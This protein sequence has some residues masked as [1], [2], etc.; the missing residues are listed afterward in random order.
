M[1]RE[2]GLIFVSFL[3]SS[4]G[5]GRRAVAYIAG[6]SLGEVSRELVY[7]GVTAAASRHAGSQHWVN[8]ARPLD[9]VGV[10]RGRMALSVSCG[11]P[12]NGQGLE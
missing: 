4:E 8:W 3:T 2:D 11:C 9:T 5:G 7:C 12:C 1:G 6:R 10:A